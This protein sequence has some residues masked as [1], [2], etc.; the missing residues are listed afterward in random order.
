M[1]RNGVF[2]KITYMTFAV[3]LLVSCNRK[4]V[5]P[6]FSINI[7]ALGI[8]FIDTLRS[9]ILV[10]ID[11]NTL[12]VNSINGEIIDTLLNYKPRGHQKR[13]C[14]SGKSLNPFFKKK[15]ESEITS[16]YKGYRIT[17]EK[18]SS[19]LRTSYKYSYFFKIY[20]NGKLVS[21]TPVVAEIPILILFYYLPTPNAVYVYC[22]YEG[23]KK[24]ILKYNYNDLIP[25]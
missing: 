7:K 9:K 16:N 20:S 17:V 12:V 25:R 3:I 24:R 21:R 2:L 1:K 15:C 23:L 14:L 5:E 11:S 22:E 4:K 6:S 18:R 13:L 10:G 8:D 19:N